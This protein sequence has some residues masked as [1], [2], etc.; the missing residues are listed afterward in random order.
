MIPRI[1]DS[2]TG[3]EVLAI[4]DAEYLDAKWEQPFTDTRP[5]PFE[6][7]GDVPMM[8][9]DGPLRAR[10]RRDPAAVH[11]RTTCASCAMLGEWREQ[12]VA[13][14]PGRRR[15]AALQHDHVAPTWPSR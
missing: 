3:D 13:A 8:V 9:V 14:R 7:V 15:A 5:A 2:F 1:V 6:G 11:G 12:H 4:T 10:R